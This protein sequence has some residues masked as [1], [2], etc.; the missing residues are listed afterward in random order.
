MWK[1][2][3]RGKKVGGKKDSGERKNQE[4]EGYINNFDDER[5]QK[6]DK[7]GCSKIEL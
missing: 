5:E 3:G 6:N 4:E 2:K 7:R 1:R